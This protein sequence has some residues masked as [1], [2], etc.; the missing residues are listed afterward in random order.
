M[1]DLV[2]T[3]LIES[4][5]S[6]G[7]LSPSYAAPERAPRPDGTAA[8]STLSS[9]VYS[10]GVSLIEIF[11]GETPVPEMRRTQ[12]DALTSRPNL[13]RLCSD[14]IGRD[15]DPTSRI[16]SQSCFETL[17][18]NFDEHES[19]LSAHEIITAKR[20]VKG[21][22]EGGAHRVELLIIAIN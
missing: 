14:L 3:R 7:P 4:S 13:L 19:Q 8:S 18:T 1:D 21:V 6:V 20:L 16:S 5:L 15:G 2:A 10:L 9:D 22:F 12:L 17:K 11:T